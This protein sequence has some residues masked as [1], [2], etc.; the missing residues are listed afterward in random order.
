MSTAKICKTKYFIKSFFI[1]SLFSLFLVLTAKFIFAQENPRT[2]TIVP[3]TVERSVNPGD[4]AEGTL[5]IVNDSKTP[6]TFKA[7]VR[8]FIVEDTIG[9]PKILADDILSKKYSASSWIAVV[10]DAFIVSPGTSQTLNYY[11]QVPLDARPGGRYAAVVY[12]PQ[13]LIGVQ[14]TG[15]GVE[16]RLG[17]LF[18]LRVSGD[19]LENATVEKFQAP[20][21]AEYGP[22]SLIT[23]IKNL[24]DVHIKPKGIITIKNM[25]GQIMETQPLPEHNIFPEAVRKFE[26]SVGKKYL[27]GRYTAE[28]Q[29]TYGINNNLTLYAT[30]N[31]FVFPW[32]IAGIV[33]LAGILA[34]LLVLYIK[35]RK[36]EKK[37]SSS[38]DHTIQ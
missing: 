1:T 36:E 30:T 9:T 33:L 13:E 32:K 26:N 19:V 10:P 17:S 29:A 21:F 38:P 4:R 20:G 24:S 28:L 16:T 34:I 35:K 15:A 2:I 37:S 18:I 12:E 14:G 7:Y 6:I 8:D 22:V 23:E 31:F 11:L 5:K 27:A 25:F 3:P